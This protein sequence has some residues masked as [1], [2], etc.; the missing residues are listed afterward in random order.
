MAKAKTVYVCSACGA[1]SPKWQGKCPNCGAWNTYVEEVIAKETTPKRPIP[2]LVSDEKARPILLRDISAEEE[3]RIDLGNEEFNRVLG[4]GLVKGSLVL[5]GGEPGIGKSTL[6]LQT[7]L[8]L[9]GLK[10]LYVSGEESSR[11]LKLRADRLADESA[12]CFILCETN[13][14]QVFVQ[15]HNVQPDLMIIDSIQTMFTEVVESSP[16]SV[17]QVRECSAS[18][19]KYAKETGVPV[20]LIGHINK[21]GSIA[22][23]K[24]LEHIVDTVLQFEGD[25][26]YM[27]RILRGVK[28]RFGSTSELGIY[29]MRQEGLREVSNPSELLLTQ[30]HEGLSGVAIAATI[31]GVRP[32]LIETQALVSTAV[33]GTPQRSSTGFDL[34]RMNML[35]AVLEKRAGF[36]LVQKDVFLNIAGGLKVNDPAID[37][38]VISAVLSSSLDIAIEAGTCM[39][40]EI[41][42]SGEIRPVNRIEQRILEAEKLG[43]KRIL[44]PH[45]NLKGFD[46]SRC[47]IQIIQVKKVEEAFRQLFG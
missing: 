42:L 43:F 10:T 9:K 20:L 30:N 25:Q 27:Y 24:V 6:V 45:S 12:N 41:G 18:L 11:Q 3:A 37:L 22:G 34:R 31:E 40:G 4:G 36:K 19:L 5:I 21:E 33:Y 13:L 17:S 46:T 1:D 32:F 35:L 29:E 23:P 14:E 26:H 39:A 8:K 44:I 28:N 7:V 2:G 38:A 15:A 16:G 47:K